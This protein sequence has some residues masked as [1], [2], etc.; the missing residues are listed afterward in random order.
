VRPA[1]VFGVLFLATL[2]LALWALG[3]FEPSAP[4]APPEPTPPTPG[5]GIDLQP[6]EPRDEPRAERPSVRN[7]THV[8]A[9]GRTA[10]PFPVWMFQMWEVPQVSYRSWFPESM[11]GAARPASRGE[12]A[13]ERAPTV[14]DVDRANVLLLDDVDPKSVAPE[15]WARVA[16]RVREGSLG[17]WIH[18][19]TQN[20]VAL[21]NEPSLA[22]LLP[23][24]AAPVRPTAPGAPTIA[25]VYPEPRTF[26]VT[27][28]GATH[29]ASRLVRWP[30]WS[31]RKWDALATG[32]KPWGTMFVHPVEGSPSPGASVLLTVRDHRGDPAPALVAS[33]PA[34]GRVLWV[35]FHDFGEPAYR[36]PGRA[37]ETFRALALSWLVWLA[38]PT[39]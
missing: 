35:G 32:T 37:D 17:L 39:S 27:E 21:S 15:V 31:R 13:L 34:R 12:S 19:G 10:R 7:A 14:E 2:A 11:P 6:S 1:I 36:D 20:G 18:P 38:G 5:G 22:P 23:V 4:T 33:D 29:P 25:G 24:T 30:T 3:V 16:E 9:L 28:A 26:Q 8:L